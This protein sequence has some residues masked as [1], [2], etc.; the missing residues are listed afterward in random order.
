MGLSPQLWRRVE[1]ALEETIEAYE[2][3]N[4]LISL[5]QDE[6][7]RRRGLR[8]I[9]CEGG[10][11]LELGSGPGNY[12][13]LLAQQVDG[14]LLCLDY[15]SRM[16]LEARRRL[17]G[18]E[19]HLV[20]G[21]FE[22]LPL[23]TSTLGIVVAAFALRDSMDRVR[24]LREVRRTLRRRGVFLLID[25]GRPTNP[26]MERLLS[27][28]LRFVVPLLAGLMVGKGL[29]NPWRLLHETYTRLPRN[30]ELLRLLREA[31]GEA[32]MEEMA[33]GSLIVASAAK[34]V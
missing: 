1:E 5:H 30:D 8:L 25:L 33:L 31:L 29:N 24:T 20:R 13:Q 16:L 17:R 27:L 4:H 7:A 23:R 19:A 6:R 14:P 11:A 2:R 12:A 22:E 28:H 32:E 34:S 21:V 26:L 3:V 18:V 15:S 9:G 10:V